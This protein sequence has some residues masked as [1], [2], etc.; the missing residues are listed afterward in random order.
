MYW[1]YMNG[2]YYLVTKIPYFSLKDD[3]GKYGEYLIYKDLRHLE[4]DGGKFLFNLYIPKNEYQKTEIDVLLICSGGLFVFESKNFGG[5]IFGNEAHQNWTQVFPKGYG[6]S[7]KEKFY[8]PI[9]Q[10]AGHIRHLRKLV[11]ENIPTHSVVVFSDRCTLKDVTVETRGVIVTYLSEIASAVDQMWAKQPGVQLTRAEIDDIY[12]R[13]Y[14]YTQV[15]HV[16]MER[17]VDSLKKWQ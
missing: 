3:A 14:A 13:L 10:N 8:N 4:G 12:G 15:G 1:Q 11:R 5:W 17:H 9:L 16:E 6:R 7:Q 2:A